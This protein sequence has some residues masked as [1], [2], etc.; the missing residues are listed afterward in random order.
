MT[1]TELRKIAQQ[2]LER[3]YG[4]APSI[5]KIVLLEANREGT[6]ILFC[7]K[8]K[9]YCFYKRTIEKREEV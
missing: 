2:A 6:Y 3:E 5:N 9:E 4:F 7:V 1:K 8:N